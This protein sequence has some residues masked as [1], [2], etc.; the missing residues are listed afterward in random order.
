[1]AN[2]GNIP[3]SSAARSG[4]LALS[5]IKD[6]IATLQTRLST[7]KRV[8]SP[9]DDPAAYFLSSDLTTRSTTLK[10]LMSNLQTAQGTVDAA[11]K[12]IA[13]LQALLASAQSIANQALQ[14]GQSL[15][16][17]TGNNAVALTTATQIATTAGTSTRFKAGDTV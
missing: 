7:G 2:V 5:G 14:A 4:V 15:A 9:L 3:M 11:N 16:T 12:G 17:V 13:A 8:N 6:Q 10:G 1:M